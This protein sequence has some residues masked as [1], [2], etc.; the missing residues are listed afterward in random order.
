MLRTSTALRSLTVVCVV[1]IA[2]RAALAASQPRQEARAQTFEVASIKM[3]TSSSPASSVALRLLPGGRVFAQN[4]PLRDVIRSAYGLEEDQVEGGPSWL[5]SDRFDIEARAPGDTATDTARAMV[6]TL[7]TDRIKLVAHTE[8]RQLQ[9]YALMVAK[10]N[11]A[12]GPSL[13]R[14]GSGCA[15]LTVPTGMPPPPPPPPGM[16]TALGAGV[17]GCPS[18]LLPGYFTLRSLDMAAFASVLWRRVVM[19]P[20]IDKT[21]LTGMFDLDLSYLPENERFNGLPAIDNPLL[22]SNSS[23]PSIFTAVQEQLGLKL[24]PTRGPV[25]VLVIDRVERPTEN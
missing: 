8:S 11:G 19:R 20:V 1:A 25:D 16:G 24:E 23:A 22:P 17:F 18:G 4:V 13:R 3:N 6:R 9:V 5:R 12:L 7:L 21:A 14:A 10:S 2:V 15:P